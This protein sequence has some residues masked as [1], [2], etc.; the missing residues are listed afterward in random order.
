MTSPAGSLPLHR[1]FT[2]LSYCP[3][4]PR[5]ESLNLSSGIHVTLFWMHIRRHWQLS[6]VF[7]S[8]LP[9]LIYRLI[10]SVCKYRSETILTWKQVLTCSV[11]RQTEHSSVDL[12]WK[13]NNKEKTRALMDYV[14]Q[15]PCQRKPHSPF[16]ELIKHHF[17]VLK[18]I[19]KPHFSV[20]NLGIPH[21]M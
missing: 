14:F 7:L 9:Y 10:G 16:Q 15:C 6:S 18:E 2:H 13:N 3:W 1:Y 21:P 20:R 11:T 12:P 17:K 5:N 19:L 4:L 8:L